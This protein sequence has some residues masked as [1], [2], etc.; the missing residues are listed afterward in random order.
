MYLKRQSLYILI[1]C[2]QLKTKINFET[3]K[4]YFYKVYYPRPEIHDI[5][6]GMAMDSEK[7]M[8]YIDNLCIMSSMVPRQVKKVWEAM[9][10]IQL[11]N[12]HNWKV[13][14]IGE[15]KFKN[16]E[17][18]IEQQHKYA[19][20]FGATLNA[21]EQENKP[22]HDKQRAKQY[23]AENRDTILEKQK[24][25][26]RQHYAENKEKYHQKYLNY[27]E[28]HQEQIKERG[29]KLC[30]CECGKEYKQWNKSSHQKTIYHQKWLEENKN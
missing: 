29:N 19:E 11:T 21:L 20:E 26:K 23:Y 2:I 1:C 16:L 13:E 10:E 27:K 25:H 4:F 18:A 9:T 15:S 3:D 14:I 12:F 7:L 28:S 5:Y 22:T 17:E 8:E 6:I 24:E 30:L